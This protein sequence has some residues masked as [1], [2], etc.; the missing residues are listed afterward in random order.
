MS[1]IR[2]ASVF[3]LCGSAALYFLA[4]SPFFLFDDHAAISQNP[5]LLNL[6]PGKL[7]DWIQVA[8][9]SES[10]P[11]GRPL[12]MLS[13]GVDTIFF[14]RPDAAAMKTTNVIVHLICALLIGF[15]VYQISLVI[16]R[17]CDKSRARTHGALLA[18]IWCLAPIH[19]ST[20]LYPVQR[21]AQFSSFFILVGLCLFVN[22]RRL[23]LARGASVAEVS[24]LGLWLALIALLAA[25]SKE[26]GVLLLWLVALLEVLLF[27]GYWAGRPLS[28]LQAA[29]LVVFFAPLLMVLVALV[30][31][32]DWILAGYQGRDFTLYQ[33]LLT[34][35]R[36]LWS[37]VGWIVLP[38]PQ[39][40]AFSHDYMKASSGLLAPL[41]TLLSIVAW[42]LAI[43]LAYRWRNR[44]PWFAL[45]LGFFLIGHSIESGFLALELVF[46]HRNYLPSVGILLIVVF[47]TAELGRRFGERLRFLPVIL[48]TL[49]F[50]S[51]LFA[52][53]QAWSDQ[54]MM[55]ALNVR[56]HPDSPRAHFFLA[57]AYELPIEQ[58]RALTS[59][60]Q[61]DLLSA[62]REH[63]KIMLSLDTEAIAPSVALYFIDDIYFP[64]NPEREI[65]LDNIE[66]AV[67]KQIF[68]SSDRNALFSFFSCA[69]ARC[70]LEKARGD[71]IIATYKKTQNR[72]AS[73]MAYSW[74][75]SNNEPDMARVQLRALQR[76]FPTDSRVH[77]LLLEQAVQEGDIDKIYEGLVRIYG[78][79][80]EFRQLANL[81]RLID[82]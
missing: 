20:V 4:A 14:G 56:H 49:L 11:L 67:A 19:V 27:K 18:A 71:R 43:L 6:D 80:K 36:V 38:S 72:A 40:L 69:V 79:D 74:H 5:A 50:S 57:R 7:Y 52:R 28:G 13:F 61:I 51:V 32:S 10:G 29:G 22:R 66:L 1:H 39:S 63:Y 47:A 23:W 31:Y 70:Q 68:S 26:N 54:F 59:M 82:E 58:S 21:M 2:A 45:G 62:A 75:V 55:A 53:T 60:Q 81:Q 9:S 25:L 12:T 78:G 33:R 44:F 37:Y 73:L 17:G 3:F 24:G 65:W 8:Q 77:F 34:Q 46:E 41:S 30:F 15:L 35:A 48:L 16:D 42:G 76:N 64:D